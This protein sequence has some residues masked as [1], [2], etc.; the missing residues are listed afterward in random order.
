MQTDSGGYYEKLHGFFQKVGIT[1]YVLCPH[2]HQQN[3]S[4]ERKHHRIVEVNLALLANTSMPLKF[5]NASFLIANFRINMLPTKVL[6]LETPTEKL[7]DIK[8]NYDSLP[9]FGCAC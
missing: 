4:A 7:L 6:N 9:V 1:H 3:V 8:P 5:C 2:A